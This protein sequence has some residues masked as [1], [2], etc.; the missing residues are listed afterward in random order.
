MDELDERL[1]DVA[2]TR[3]GKFQAHILEHGGRMIRGIDD[4]VAGLE[5]TFL[6]QCLELF[7]GVDIDPR[8]VVQVLRVTRRR[9]REHI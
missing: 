5:L 1:A 6:P 8:A 9:D 4:R 2:V 7:G 3:A